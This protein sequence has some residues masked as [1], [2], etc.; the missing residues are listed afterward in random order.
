M[1]PHIPHYIP[2]FFNQ[3]CYP[4]LTGMATLDTLPNLFLIH[5]PTMGYP[6][7]Q[8][9]MR[10]KCFLLLNI[11]SYQ[12][13]LGNCTLPCHFSKP[14]RIAL[15]TSCTVLW[16]QN[17]SLRCFIPLSH[18][19]FALPLGHCVTCDLSSILLWCWGHLDT[20]QNCQC[21]R[22][23][24]GQRTLKCIS[25]PSSN[26]QPL[27]CNKL[28]PILPNQLSAKGNQNS[29]LFFQYFSMGIPFM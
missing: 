5:L 9:P 29:N 19:T 2:Q 3:F 20:K 21:F 27:I 25:P 11:M 1:G 8:N 16:L 4:L 26:E 28:I 18:T 13:W 10:A 12:N 24:H 14:Q 17:H 23:S 15:A 6:A 22:F 7:I